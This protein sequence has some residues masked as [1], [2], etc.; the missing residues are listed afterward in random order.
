MSYLMTVPLQLA[1]VAGPLGL[2]IAY[3]DFG[4]YVYFGSYVFVFWLVMARYN[5]MVKRALY[6]EFISH[7]YILDFPNKA[8]WKFKI[9]WGAYI[10][11]AI[12]GILCSSLSE[13][14]KLATIMS[15]LSGG[16]DIYGE[17]KVTFDLEVNTLSVNQFYENH[18]EMARSLGGK[19]KMIP[20]QIVKLVLFKF[21][22]DAREAN[23]AV[24]KILEAAA[25]TDVE[26]AKDYTKFLTHS[27]DP[28]IVKSQNEARKVVLDKLE[29]KHRAHFTDDGNFLLLDTIDIIQSAEDVM[30][31]AG[32]SE[33]VRDANSFEDDAVKEKIGQVITEMNESAFR[34]MLTF[35]PETICLVYQP[36]DARS[37]D[38][39]K[40]LGIMGSASMLALLYGLLV[41]L[42]GDGEDDC[43]DDDY[44]DDDYYYYSSS[45][46]SSS[47]Y[48]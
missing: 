1:A 3:S 42:L 24:V 16:N 30:D 41:G 33:M 43:G 10:L 32:I 14:V 13:G 39:K 31:T 8:L 45:Y 47:Y 46:Y 15:L 22:K 19:L 7:G 6:Y 23:E 26:K 27:E 4:F 2:C 37:A 29:S 20:Y 17:N 12:I 34:K 9:A 28:E 36:F 38:L 25:T 11:F 48:S 18:H 5:D 35:D 21:S 44:D 40:L